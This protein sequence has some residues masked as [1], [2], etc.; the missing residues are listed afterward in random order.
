MLIIRGNDILTS[1]LE[2]TFSETFRNDSGLD[3]LV[4]LIQ[5]SLIDGSKPMKGVVL[6]D[7]V[8]DETYD[9]GRYLHFEV[10]QGRMYRFVGTFCLSVVIYFALCLWLLAGLCQPRGTSSLSYNL[11]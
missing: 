11:F 9:F 2:L 1:I 6:V 8:V 7:S 5:A 3:D 4:T 10:E